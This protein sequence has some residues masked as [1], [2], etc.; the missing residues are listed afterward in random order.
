M[1]PGS[2]AAGGKLRGRGAA[3]RLA[4]EPRKFKPHVT[5]AY[6]HGTLDDEVAPFLQVGGVQD[7]QVLGRSFLHVFL[8]RDQGGQP[9]CGAV[10]P[11]T[12]AGA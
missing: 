4:P 12:G 6:L 7:G 1:R 5:L 2:G 3:G 9:L 11:L 10:Y 8:A